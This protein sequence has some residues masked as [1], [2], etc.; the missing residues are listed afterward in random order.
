MFL[1]EFSDGLAKSACQIQ[2][3]M[4]DA[5]P[6]VTGFSCSNPT[7]VFTQ[8]VV[9][10]VETSILDVPTAAAPV[11]QFGRAGPFP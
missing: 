8:S 5:A 7:G 3:G 1:A 10:N 2:H 4:P 11:E 6:R 9:Q